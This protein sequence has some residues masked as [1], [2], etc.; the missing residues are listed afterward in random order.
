MNHYETWSV[1]PGFHWRLSASKVPDY[2]KLSP[3]VPVETEHFSQQTNQHSPGGTARKNQ[4][5]LIFPALSTPEITQTA[6]FYASVRWV[7]QKTICKF[8]L[9]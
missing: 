5:V 8:P 1:K 7:H 9:K 6:L 3:Q 2:Y 4:K